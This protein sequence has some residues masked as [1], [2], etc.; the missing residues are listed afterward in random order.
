MVLDLGG[1]EPALVFGIKKKG[2]VPTTISTHGKD[3][4]WPT[5]P[6]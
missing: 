4:L 3:E 2:I 5:T 6:F 1:A